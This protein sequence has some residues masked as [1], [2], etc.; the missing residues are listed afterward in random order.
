LKKSTG[1]KAVPYTVLVVIIAI[2]LMYLLG[3]IARM[4]GFGFGMGVGPLGMPR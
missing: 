4:L 1:D 2:V 3:L